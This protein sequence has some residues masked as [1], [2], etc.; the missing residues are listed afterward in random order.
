MKYAASRILKYEGCRVVDLS[1][2]CE[3]FD[4]SRIWPKFS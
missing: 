4:L 2:P 1:W 3:A